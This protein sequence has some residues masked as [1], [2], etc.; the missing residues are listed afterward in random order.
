MK[1]TKKFAVIT[2]LLALVGA[3]IESSCSS[4]LTGEEKDHP[5][6]SQKEKIEKLAEEY[7]LCDY[8]EHR[9]LTRADSCSDIEDEFALFSS[10]V[11]HYEL[12]G[13]QENY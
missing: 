7:G 8:L 5:S 4:E 2:V 1:E 3:V 6:L 13:S 11:G 9:A 12:Y 10:F